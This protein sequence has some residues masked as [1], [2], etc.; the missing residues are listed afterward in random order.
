MRL[1]ITGAPGAGKGTVA[2]A[3]AEHYDIPAISTGNM[4]RAAVASGS[5]LGQKLAAIMASGALVPDDVTDA[6]VEARLKEP[7]AVLGWLLDG[8]PRTLAQV[9][10]LDG[11]LERS[12]EALDAVI[13]LEVAAETIL[14]RLLRR[15]TIEGR[16]D[17]TEEV[18]RHRLAV[19]EAS[20]A[21]IIDAYD[22]RGLVLKVDGEG[23]PDEVRERLDAALVARL[24]H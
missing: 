7:D 6:V 18:I 15:A 4:F 23:T 16:S 10:T 3:I 5:E 21:P 2:G 22:Q 19:Y 14:T 20:T 17:D 13:V 8:Y 9:E 12:G 1:L 24:G 11:I